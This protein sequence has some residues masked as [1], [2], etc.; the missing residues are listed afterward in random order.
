MANSVNKVCVSAT[1]S[2]FSRPACRNW[3]HCKY[4]MSP[5]GP[6][7]TKLRPSV[8]MTARKTHCSAVDA[9][10]QGSLKSKIR[11]SMLLF[12]GAKMPIIG[13]FPNF[14]N[15]LCVAASGRVEHNGQ[16]AVVAPDSIE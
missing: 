15:Q 11:L 12:L 3:L 5:L 14:Y 10:S 6:V 16:S 4:R 9:L 2:W 8:P 7:D 1:G 13:E